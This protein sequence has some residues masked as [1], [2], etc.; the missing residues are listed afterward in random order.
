MQKHVKVALTGAAGQIGYATLFRLAAGEMFGKDTTIDLQL[1]ELEPA[2]PFLKGI[3]MELKDGAFPL[4]KNIT[5][6]SNLIQGFSGVNWALLIGAL[7]RK[8]GMERIDLLKGNGAIFKAQG[9]ALN[10]AA[11][12]NV[13]IFVVGNPCNTNCLITLHHAPRIARDRFYAMTLLDEKRARYQ[14]AEKAKVSVTA[15]SQMAVWGNHSV[16]QYPDFYHAKINGKPVIES[17]PD[18]AWLENDFIAKVQQRGAEVIQARGSSSA[19]SAAH[20]IVSS[21]AQL[22]DDTPLSEFYSMAR[23]S[24]GEY[25]IDEGLI[26]SYPCRTENEISKVV[27]G[28][29]HNAF[30]QQKLNITLEELRKEKESVKQLGFI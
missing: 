9:E 23:V 24:Q 21:I 2:L 16:T 28:L 25:G 29:T 20:A 10:Q 7:P 11:A 1:I 3:V 8:P 14:L 26:F 18:L 4:L 13:Q 17:I 27:T 6:T 22:V 15:V 12:D 19:G 5:I 30:G